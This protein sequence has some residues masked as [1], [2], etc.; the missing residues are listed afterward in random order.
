MTKILVSLSLCFMAVSCMTYDPYTDEQ[1]ISDSTKGA[2]LGGVAGAVLGNQVRGNRRTRDQA[3][4]AGAVLGAAI[5][6]TIGHE[7]DKREASLRHR[8]RNTGV[9]IRKESDGRLVLTTPGSITFDTNSSMIKPEFSEILDSIAIVLKEYSKS[10]VEVSG[11]CDGR[12]S[13]EAN[14]LLSQQRA[15]AV[16]SYL[17]THGIA[18]SR[19]TAVGYGKSA[20]VGR[21]DDPQSRRVEIE[22]G[23]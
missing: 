18:G 16:A 5:G 1:K 21:K 22:I 8:L 6:G 23:S 4:I 12:G 9:G 19:L 7:M 10:Q 3:E 20:A 15:N 2:V 11:H 17:R 13:M 14:Q